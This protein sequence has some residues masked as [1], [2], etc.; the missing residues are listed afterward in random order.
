M[1]GLVCVWTH[2]ECNTITN[3]IVDNDCFIKRSFCKMQ[4]TDQGNKCI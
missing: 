2:L 3:P 1:V 4:V